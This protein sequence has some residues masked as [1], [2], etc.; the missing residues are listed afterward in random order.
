MHAHILP[1]IVLGR[2]VSAASVATTPH[3]RRVCGPIRH[4]ADT[5]WGQN[6]TV[7]SSTC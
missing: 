5:K 4:H 1:H 3:A 2:F 7:V 6:G